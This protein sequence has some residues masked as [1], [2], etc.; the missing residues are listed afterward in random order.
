MKTQVLLPLTRLTLPPTTQGRM[1]DADLRL[2]LRLLLSFTR[3]KRRRRRR[4]KRAKAR[5][6][7]LKS[8]REGG[9]RADRVCV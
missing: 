2:T 6:R 1:L 9:T 5:K 8:R 3:S 7:R 4:R